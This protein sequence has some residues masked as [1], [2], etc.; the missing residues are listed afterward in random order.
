MQSLGA[1]EPTRPS[2]NNASCCF[3]N[4]CNHGIWKFLSLWLSVKIK[5]SLVWA[6][7]W[8]FTSWPHPRFCLPTKFGCIH[9]FMPLQTGMLISLLPLVPPTPFQYVFFIDLHRHGCLGPND[10]L[11]CCLCLVMVCTKK[12]LVRTTAGVVSVIFSAFTMI[13]ASG[14]VACLRSPAAVPFSL[15]ARFIFGSEWYCAH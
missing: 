14:G 4:F 10:A 8:Y 13:F 15:L 3:F 7:G 9:L 6:W 11:L 1:Q 2:Q 12:A 5:L